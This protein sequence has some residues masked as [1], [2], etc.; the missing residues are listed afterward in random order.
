MTD[1]SGGLLNPTNPDEAPVRRRALAILNM[2]A[3]QFDQLYATWMKG[4]R[5][6]W[7]AE[8]TSAL[9]A[10]MGTHAAELFDLSQKTIV[11]LE[12]LRPG[13]TA[14]GRSLMRPFTIHED[15]TITLDQV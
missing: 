10:E 12:Q 8:D 3:K 5:E 7:L 15:G 1:F 14:H 9:L 11:F 2:P 13:C 4:V 6:I